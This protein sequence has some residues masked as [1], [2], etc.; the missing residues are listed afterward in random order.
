MALTD[1]ERAWSELERYVASKPS[2][3]ARDLALEMISIRARCAEDESM[4]E[5]A[6]RLY[7]VQLHEDLRAAARDTPPT[8]PERSSPRAMA[9]KPGHHSRQEDPDVRSNQGEARPLA[10]RA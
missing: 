4:P 7:G 1:F 3:G 2:H 8:P 6:M 5:R 9:V 10:R